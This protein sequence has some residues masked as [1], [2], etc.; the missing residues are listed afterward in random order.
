[1]FASARWSRP[2]VQISVADISDASLVKSQL[3]KSRRKVNRDGTCSNV[4]VMAEAH[5]HSD[6]SAYTLH[7]I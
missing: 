4:S 5:V 7:Y 1:M 3:L 6:A 2:Q